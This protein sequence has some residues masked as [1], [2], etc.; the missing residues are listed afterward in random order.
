MTAIQTTKEAY[1]YLLSLKFVFIPSKWEKKN[2][3]CDLEMKL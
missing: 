3:E 1:K 2:T